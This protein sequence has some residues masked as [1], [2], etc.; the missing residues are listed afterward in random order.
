MGSLLLHVTPSLLPLPPEPGAPKRHPSR[1]ALQPNNCPKGLSVLD[2]FQPLLAE[3]LPGHRAQH[4]TSLGPAWEDGAL[5]GSVC[6]S[7][8][9]VQQE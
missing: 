8:P 3:M 5:H 2:G 4:R 1:S 7:R 9:C 6:G